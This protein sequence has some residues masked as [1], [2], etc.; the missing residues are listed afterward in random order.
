MKYISTDVAKRLLA[1]ADLVNLISDRL[2]FD[3]I[4]RQ[5]A[6]YPLVLVSDISLVPEYSL[7]GEVDAQTSQIQVDYWTDGKEA[8]QGPKK[9]KE[10]GELIAT[11][12]SG[13]RGQLGDNT[14]C[15]SCRIIRSN[16]LASQPLPGSDI[17]RRFSSHDF[18]IISS[19]LATA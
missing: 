13:Y 19:T 2:Y 9:A 1:N 15:K 10:G 6:V 17:H 11:I 8:L 12:L 7:D 4:P 3:G 14:D 16:V 18:E 5:G